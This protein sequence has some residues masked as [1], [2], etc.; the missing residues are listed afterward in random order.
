M[1]RHDIKLRLPVLYLRGHKHAEVN[2]TLTKFPPPVH[3][4]SDAASVGD[5]DDISPESA[6]VSQLS[7]T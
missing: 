1:D 6:P 2:S 5:S 4:D 7:F 3:S